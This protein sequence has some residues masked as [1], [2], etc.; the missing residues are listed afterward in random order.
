MNNDIFN[1]REDRVRIKTVV[2][3]WGVQK[4]VW[5]QNGGLIRQTPQG[6]GTQYTT[7]LSVSLCSRSGSVRERTESREITRCSQSLV[8]KTYA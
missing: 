2:R 3:T 7:V 1:V 5:V 4:H 6:A 8:I